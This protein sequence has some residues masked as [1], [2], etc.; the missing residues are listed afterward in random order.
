[1]KGIRFKENLKN[2]KM[3]S[4]EGNSFYYK[5]HIFILYI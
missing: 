2:S 5:K 4:D 3:I 1:M